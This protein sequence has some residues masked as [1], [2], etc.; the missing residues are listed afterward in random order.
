MKK[1]IFLSLLVIFTVLII[2]SCSKLDIKKDI[3]LEVEF[4]A[5]TTATEFNILE[6]FDVDSASSEIADYSDKITK[7]EITDATVWL[8]AFNGPA[9][10]KINTA[11]LSVADENGAGEEIIGTIAD[12]DLASLLDNP[13]PFTLNQAGVDRFAD[14]IKSSPHKALIKF[15]G[16]TNEAPV[17]F[18][19]KF[20]F[21]VKMTANPL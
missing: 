1:G 17:D 14:L 7:I 18:T 19:A 10:Q 4:V 13:I 8:T 12:Q 20:K 2:I 15:L 5:D 3:D 16:S 21:K 9:G 6:L 11:T